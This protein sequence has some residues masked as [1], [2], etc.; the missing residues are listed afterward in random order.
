[1]ASCVW[2][3]LADENSISA[4]FATVGPDHTLAD[5]VMARRV[6]FGPWD[7]SSDVVLSIA[8]VNHTSA[9]DATRGADTPSDKIRVVIRSADG[10]S[11]GCTVTGRARLS[12]IA[13]GYAK[14][15]SNG[16]DDTTYR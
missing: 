4:P 2:E 3:V 12:R 9:Q 5:I 1:M 16:E 15:V 6:D 10:N 14:Q 7:A 13:E 8:P 11:V